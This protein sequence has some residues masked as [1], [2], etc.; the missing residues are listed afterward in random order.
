MGTI[1]AGA[2]CGARSCPGPV[3]AEF[4]MPIVSGVEGSGWEL[5]RKMEGKLDRFLLARFPK[6]QSR[7]RN[8]R[9]SFQTSDHM[10][11]SNVETYILVT[12]RKGITQYAENTFRYY[13]GMDRLQIKLIIAPLPLTV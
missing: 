11:E 5:L 6:C 3:V 10:F 4:D 7:R 1:A 2:P 8:R 13:P 9:V 12:N